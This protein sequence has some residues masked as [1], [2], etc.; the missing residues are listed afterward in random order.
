MGK[1]DGGAFDQNVIPELTEVARNNISFSNSDLLAGG[2]Y[3]A[4]GSTWTMGG[5]FAQTS[6]LPLK[7]PIDGNAM[8]NQDLFMP[9]VTSIG[10][11]LAEQGYRQS[12][13][14]G[15][16]A[17]VWRKKNYF[18]QHGNYEMLDYGWA[19]ANGKIPPDY[20]VWWGYEDQKL[21]DIAK[22]K[23]TEISMTGQPF[24]FTM[25]TVD[26]HFEDGY[27]CE[28]CQPVTENQYANV[29]LCASISFRN[30][31]HGSNSRAFIRN[32]TIVLS[33]DHL[34]MDSDFC[35]N[36]DPSYE[37]TVYNAFINPAV[38]PVQ[39]KNRQFTTMDMFPSTLASMGVTI[40]GER[41]GLGTNLF[42]A[43]PTLAEQYEIET[44][45]EELVK[46]S[47]FFD[48]FVSDIKVEGEE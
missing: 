33:G 37:R 30:F 46:E 2:A 7:I 6:G 22:E 4:F 19:N 18:E 47:K 41:L 12:L 48:N 3:P 39:T 31:L 38:M 25:L 43:E 17:E 24:N 44:I 26:T 23:L 5:M 9:A 20:R 8:S 34:T 29:Y 16:D 42:S 36:I 40:Q 13:L 21:F 10:D 15:S 28:K 27:Y 11:I 35:L 32:T 45:D 1:E 14:I